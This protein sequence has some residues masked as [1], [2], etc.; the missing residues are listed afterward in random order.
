MN[1]FIKSDKYDK[2]D[3]NYVDEQFFS[4]ILNN[5]DLDSTLYPTCNNKNSNDNSND[6]DLGNV[7]E[8]YFHDFYN[9][10]KK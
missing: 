2:N 8:H 6:S 4:R 9:K 7:D 3:N 1:D 5:N 10:L